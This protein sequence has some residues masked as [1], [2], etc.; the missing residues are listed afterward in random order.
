ML[1]RIIACFDDLLYSIS[2]SSSSSLS[3]AAIILAWLTSYSCS[4]GDCRDRLASLCEAFS[5]MLR[6]FSG[7]FTFGFIRNGM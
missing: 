7:C 4:L 1:D 3:K 5:V 6:V 2:T